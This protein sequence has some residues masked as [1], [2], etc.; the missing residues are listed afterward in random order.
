M[1]DNHVPNKISS[2]TNHFNM[3]VF[4]RHIGFGGRT[5]HG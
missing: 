1:E 2:S 4:I 5:F 3:H